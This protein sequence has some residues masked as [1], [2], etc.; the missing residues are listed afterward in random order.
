[1]PE[2]LRQ[3]WPH[4]LALLHVGLFLIATVHIVLRK[5]DVRAAIG[6]AGLVWLVPIF[7]SL[8]Y[9]I[10]GINRIQR[11]AIALRAGESWKNL[12]DPRLTPEETQFRE[13]FAGEHPNLM[14]LAALCRKLT[15]K[16]ALPGNRVDPLIDGDEAYPAM[17]A[18]IA[19]AERSIAL[20]SYIFD[21]DR[22]GEMFLEALV[23]A[24]GRGIEV[25]VLID[26]VGSRYSRP[27]MVHR[28]RAAGLRVAAFLPSRTP[29]LLR[30]ANLRNHRKIL[31][32]DGRVGFTGGTNIR[33]GH[34]LSL[35]PKEPVQ[36]LHFRLEGPAVRHLQEVFAIDWAFAANESIG[37]EIWF[38]EIDRRG[39]VW[40]RGI[41]DGPDEDF[42]KLADAMFGALAA[43]RRSVHIVTPY[44]LPHASLIDALNSAAMRGVRVEIHLPEVN[45]IK[46]VQWAA[47]AQYWQLLEKGCRIFLTPPPFDHTKLM[48]VDGLWSLIGSTNWDPRSLRLNFEFNV[49][50]Y[51]P[52]LTQRL[53]ALVQERLANA[54][55]VTLEEVRGLPFGE[56][57]RNGLARLL[58]PYL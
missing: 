46:L 27:N 3:A 35:N 4:L 24:Q 11:Q 12:P 55:E 25:R 1:M 26:D 53:E 42:E 28:L 54:R 58:S 37:G 52:E 20:Q 17:L 30:Y 50:C 41:S 19:G 7:G 29:K 13:R 22:V 10:L 40:A 18:A 49:E 47:A 57:L 2:W 32:V 5:R 43:A 16:A 56:Q 48:L 14:G 9:F 6:W 21:S 44:F 33:E 39:P 51:G 45:N 8:A 15:G 36:C 31:V 34:W 38:P 23:A